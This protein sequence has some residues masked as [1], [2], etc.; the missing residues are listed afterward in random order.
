MLIK[1]DIAVHSHTLYLCA[2]DIRLFGGSVPS[3]GR[4][5]LF[6]EGGWRRVAGFGFTAARVAC[7]QVGYPYSDGTRDFGQGNSTVWV[8]IWSCNGDE[9]RVEQC[10]HTGWKI[11]TNSVTGVRCRGKCLQGVKYIHRNTIS[12]YMC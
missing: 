12:L 4:V 10:L 11:I 3:E 8:V 7:R 5:E 1:R 6:Y 2:G 9:E